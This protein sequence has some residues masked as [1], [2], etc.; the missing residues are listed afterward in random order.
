MR[1]S[2][3]D[4]SP[5]LGAT[6]RDPESPEKTTVCA[7]ICAIAREVHKCLYSHESC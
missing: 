1:K 3:G 2:Y 4:A 7:R 5:R 6:L